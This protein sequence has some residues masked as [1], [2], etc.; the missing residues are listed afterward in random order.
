MFGPSDISLG[1]PSTSLR[2]R[3][4]SNSL[5]KEVGIQKYHTYLMETMMAERSSLLDAWARMLEAEDHPDQ[6]DP[7][8]EALVKQ[9]I[10]RIADKWTMI[11][12]DI[13]AQHGE[14]RFSQI[15]RLAGKVSQKMLTQ[16][17]RQL[18][19]DGLVVRTV[20]PVVPPKVEYRL[21]PLGERLGVAFCGVWIWAA[22]SLEQVERA[23]LNFDAA[24]G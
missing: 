12:L 20:H 8:V 15:G 1:F 7:K 14:L 16:T 10:G 13:L 3:V 24:R 6:V 23:R 4:T 17:L 11:V 9:L 19:R 2:Q 22:E 18:E 21:T 5:R